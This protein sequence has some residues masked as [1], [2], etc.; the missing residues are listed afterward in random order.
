MEVVSKTQYGNQVSG[1]HSAMDII[2]IKNLRL[3]CVLGFSS[4]ELDV[5]QDIVI[6]LRVGVDRRLAGESDAPADAFNYKTLNKAVI[7]L[8]T[9]SRYR[10]V[11]KLAEEIAR[12]AI[13]DFGA[14]WIA[15]KVEKP[16]A[17]RHA[18][19]VSLRIERTAA[20]YERNIVFLTLG[21]NIAP[22]KNLARA[23]QLL[24]E[25]TTVLRLSSVYQT[26]PQ[27]YAPQ[28]DFLNMAVKCHTVRQP[29]AFKTDVIDAIEAQ[30]GR[31][32][33]PQNKN[34]P[35]TIDI[36]IALWNDERREY[37]EKPWRIPDPDITR[38]AHA[39]LPLADLAPD[40]VV[41]GAGET[42]RVIAAGMDK[43]SVKMID[44][45]FLTQPN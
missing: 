21:S 3:R 1:L 31:V 22:K 5:M 10:L 12:L 16:G 28:A 17:L 44:G 34:A 35:R 32:R 37:G 36:D 43:S 23:I 11:E 14:A 38:F 6:N 2:D 30:L 13:V 25:K 20:D 8:V 24:R 40:Y 41:P 27:G 4:H 18:D 45:G 42:L 15:A 7:G 29:L 19:S 33:D 26:A 9:G 39:A